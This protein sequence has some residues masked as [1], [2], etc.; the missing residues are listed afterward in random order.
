[1][2]MQDLMAQ[3]QQLQNA[4]AAAQEKLANT[5]VRGVAGDGACVVEM[6]GKYDLLEI[7]LRDDISGK[8]ANEISQ[9]VLTAMRDAKHKAD[10]IIDNVMGDATAGMPI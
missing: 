8:S 4:V 7:M 5:T 3:A 6:T 9:I 1:M 2:E 10:E